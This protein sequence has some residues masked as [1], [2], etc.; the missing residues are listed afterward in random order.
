MRSV[1]L[2][3]LLLMICTV[4][5]FGIEFTSIDLEQ[6]YR[7][8]EESIWSHQQYLYPQWESITFLRNDMYRL[9]S[10][11]LNYTGELDSDPGDNFS[12]SEDFADSVVRIV[13]PPG[14]DILVQDG[15]E[16]NTLRVAGRP[17]ANGGFSPSY[18]WIDLL[19]NLEGVGPRS[20]VEWFTV[21]LEPV[22]GGE[23]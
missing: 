22:E 19:P 9:D 4:A 18:K 8:A 17:T 3:L 5:L 13:I 14:R 15:V 16:R 6:P 7:F 21:R 23:D 11:I 10:E 20:S 12:L 2:L 1:T